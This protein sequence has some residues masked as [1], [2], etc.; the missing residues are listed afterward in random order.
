VGHS[1]V[2]GQDDFVLLLGTLGPEHQLLVHQ[3]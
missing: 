3:D 1:L 2:P